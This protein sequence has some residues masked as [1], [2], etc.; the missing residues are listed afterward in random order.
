MSYLPPG[1]DYDSYCEGNEEQ[2]QHESDRT[3]YRVMLQLE[4][5]AGE[6]ARV[7][8]IGLEHERAE[9]AKAYLSKAIAALDDDVPEAA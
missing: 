9:Q 3:L 8:E 5:L 6:L 4:E 2:A 7:E 1:F